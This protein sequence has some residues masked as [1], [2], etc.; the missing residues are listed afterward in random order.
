MPIK[1]R[2]RPRL[3]IRCHSGR[4]MTRA[5][6]WPAPSRRRRPC[7]APFSPTRRSTSS[8]RW[9]AASMTRSCGWTTATSPSATACRPGPT[10]WSTRSTR[11]SPAWWSGG[12]CST[13]PRCA[14]LATGLFLQDIGML[15]L[16]ESLVQKPGPLAP[17]EWELMMKHPLLGLEFLRDDSVS[18]RGQVG[19]SLA[20][21]ALG[22]LRL[23]GRADRRGDLAVRPDR[24]GGRRVRRR[25]ERA[26]PRARRAA[27]RGR[28]DRPRRRRHR[29]RP[30][31]GR[32]LPRR[33][34]RR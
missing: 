10:S 34:S 19:G 24:R 15:V 12:G 7:R 27:R 16:P 21:R 22:R 31:G 32:R 29:V 11:P 23:P 30:A 28:G 25:D 1:P 14:D 33:R 18:A 8:P 6:R 17:D 20:P 13:R 5:P 26:L 9:P 2:W 3:R 4:A